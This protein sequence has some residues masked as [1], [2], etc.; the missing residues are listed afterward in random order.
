MN[1]HTSVQFMWTLPPSLRQ[2]IVKN[3]KRVESRLINIWHPSFNGVRVATVFCTLRPSKKVPNAV[4]CFVRTNSNSN[5]L[6]IILSVG[7]KCT[8]LP[9]QPDGEDSL[10]FRFCKHTGDTTRY[11]VAKSFGTCMSKSFLPL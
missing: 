7:Y 6:T 2:E 10:Q 1:F 4:Q 9:D 11:T 3:K 8:L 5:F